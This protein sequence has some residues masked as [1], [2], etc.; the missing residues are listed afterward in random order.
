MRTRPRSRETA[1]GALLALALT[2][3]W[4][5]GLAQASPGAGNTP[6]DGPAGIITVSFKLDPRL[7][8]PTYGGERWVSPPTYTG[9]S[10]QDT[11][12][13]RAQ[14]M[15]AKGRPSDMA[16]QWTP[17]DPGMVSVTPSQGNQVKIAVKRTGESKLKVAS[18]SV[19]KEFLIKARYQGKAIQV[20]IVQLG[21]GQ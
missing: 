11:V 3:G 21:S 16:L 19:S 7:S 13:A 10:A 5:S 4:Y 1:S 8:G 6:T 18:Q 2:S 15:D 20:E 12:E 14:A 9:A 17:A